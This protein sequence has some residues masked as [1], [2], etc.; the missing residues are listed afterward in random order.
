MGLLW[1]DIWCEKEAISVNQLS[2]DDFP[3]VFSCQF[4]LAAT[5]EWVTR[6]YL[7]KMMLPLRECLF[8]LRFFLWQLLFIWLFFPPYIRSTMMER[9][10]ARSRTGRITMGMKLWWMEMTRDV[11]YCLVHV[12]SLQVWQG[13]FPSFIVG[14]LATLVPLKVEYFPIPI[15][16]GDYPIIFLSVSI[17]PS[18]CCTFVFAIPSLFLRSLTNG[19]L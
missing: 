8:P 3:A 10:V 9:T 5:R 16:G 18:V 7:R 1:H 12:F 15:L 2:S 17:F 11:G 4:W 19:A 14:S 13:S 6:A